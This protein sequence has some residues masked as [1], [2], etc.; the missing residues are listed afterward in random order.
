MREYTP[1]FKPG[2]SE[3]LQQN[4][5]W[6]GVGVFCGF[7]W[8]LAFTVIFLRDLICPAKNLLF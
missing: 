7:I 1:E 8:G 2:I 4:L 3:H 6:A 5:W